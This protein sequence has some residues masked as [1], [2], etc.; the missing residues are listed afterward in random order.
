[1][2]IPPLWVPETSALNQDRTA[3]SFDENSSKNLCTHD[4]YF[5]TCTL[6]Q[7]ANDGTPRGES[8]LSDRL[9]YVEILRIITM[10][11]HTRLPQVIAQ[12]ARR[13]TYL[14][15]EAQGSN[16]WGQRFGWKLHPCCDLNNQRCSQSSPSLRR[17]DWQITPNHATQTFNNVDA[18]MHERNCTVAVG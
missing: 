12:R 1:M 14:L 11:A 5:N 17:W 15:S 13:S 9:S 3:G 18:S 8:M 16:L 6:S 2:L 7:Q 4:H 10:A